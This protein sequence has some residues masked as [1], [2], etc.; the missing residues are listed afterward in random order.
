MLAIVGVAAYVSMAFAIGAG[1]IASVLIFAV[2]YGRHSGVLQS[3][4][5]ELERSNVKRPEAERSV[6]TSHGAAILV[7]HL[8]GMLFFGTAAQVP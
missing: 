1:M 2:D 5:A 3:A 7:L 6:L 8:R 4:T